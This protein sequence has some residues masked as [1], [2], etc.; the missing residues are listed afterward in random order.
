MCLVYRGN[1][2]RGLLEKAFEG[3]GYKPKERLENAA[4]LG[5]I[6]L[7][8]LVHPTITEADMDRVCGV[9]RAVLTEASKIVD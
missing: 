3:T 1:L 4:R 7:C 8:L 2:F 5:D 6:S 9:L